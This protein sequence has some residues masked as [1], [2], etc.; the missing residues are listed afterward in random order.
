MPVPHNRQVAQPSAA[1][2]TVNK[3]NTTESASAWLWRLYDWRKAGNGAYHSDRTTNCR[4]NHCARY[5]IIV[6]AVDK[7]VHRKLV[8]NLKSYSHHASGR[9][10]VRQWAWTSYFTV[11]N[12]EC[13]AT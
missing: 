3:A 10:I 1:K 12:V 9:N 4:W 8:V 11:E 5:E 2:E 7:K 13:V 6:P